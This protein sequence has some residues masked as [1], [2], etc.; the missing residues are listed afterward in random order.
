ME[1]QCNLLQVPQVG[2]GHKEDRLGQL[3][4]ASICQLSPHI[5]NVLDLEIKLV[6]CV[7]FL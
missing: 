2:I 4:S 3:F 6:A 1:R 5:S 7:H